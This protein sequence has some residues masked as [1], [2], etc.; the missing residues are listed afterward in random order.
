MGWTKMGDRPI[1]EIL[2][3]QHRQAMRDALAGLLLA[4]PDERPDEAAVQAMVD[5]VAAGKKAKVL[6]EIDK[7]I[8]K[9]REA[10]HRLVELVAAHE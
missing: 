8:D 2:Y 10:L 1:K 3:E 5:E 4:I 6:K 7:L 9:H